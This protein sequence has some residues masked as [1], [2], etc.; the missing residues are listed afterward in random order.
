MAKRTYKNSRFAGEMLVAAE[1]A[2]LGYE[3]T[4][5]NVGGYQTKGFDL[6]AGDPATGRT[7][8]ISVKSLKSHNSFFIDPETVKL[9]M[10]YVFVV[11]GPAGTLP[12]FYVV[13]GSTLL[14]DEDRYFG[15]WGRSYQKAGRGIA[16]SHLQ[17]FKD[18]W[19]AFDE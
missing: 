1:L 14:A 7:V 10:V 8:G 17:D 16:P 2:R 5:G 3:V 12:T 9:G 4:L 6:M 19:K 13:K 18:N 15:K 11:T